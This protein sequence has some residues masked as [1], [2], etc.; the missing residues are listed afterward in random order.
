MLFGLGLP[1]FIKRWR[2][3]P[4]AAAGGNRVENWRIGGYLISVVGRYLD[5]KVVGRSSFAEWGQPRLAA[6][7]LKL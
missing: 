1:C 6:L 7:E 4:A 3:T 5:L 2:T